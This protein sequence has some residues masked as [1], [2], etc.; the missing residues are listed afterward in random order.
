MIAILSGI[1]SVLWDAVENT[2]K[3]QNIP[4]QKKIEHVYVVRVGNDISAPRMLL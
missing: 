2:A 1:P 4:P 3:Q